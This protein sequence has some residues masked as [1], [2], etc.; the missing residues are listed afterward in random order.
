MD[1]TANSKDH[2][3]YQQLSNNHERSRGHST[4]DEGATDDEQEDL[5]YD[6]ILE[7]YLAPSL[8]CDL[9]NY[10]GVPSDCLQELTKSL[11]ES[12]LVDISIQSATTSDEA[13]YSFDSNNEFS[14]SETISKSCE[15]KEY[16]EH[17]SENL[18]SIPT[19][20]PDVL[21]RHFN[22][23]SLLNPYEF[24]D[25]ETMP[26]VS[27]AESSDETVISRK[28][29]T[30]HSL[31]NTFVEDS[32]EISQNENTDD[33]EV[34][35]INELNSD[36]DQTSLKEDV[37]E[38]DE[39]GEEFC[40]LPTNNMDK[41]VQQPKQEYERRLS[42]SDIKYGQGQV[43]YK[44]PDFSKVPSK[45]KIPKGD[46]GNIKPV[47]S[48]KR[49]TS[50][51]NLS[52]QSFIIQDILDSMQPFTEHGLVNDSSVCSD[53]LQVQVSQISHYASHSK[54]QITSIVHPA[55]DFH[56]PLGNTNKQTEDSLNGIQR[57]DGL[58]TCKSAANADRQ[59]PNTE[60]GQL[61]TEGE[62]MSRTLMEQVQELKN[63][64]ESFSDCIFV[65]SLTTKEES[66]IF[67][68]LR[69]CL[70]S[71][72]LNYLSSKDKHRNLQLQ[73]Y[74]TGCQTVGEFDVEREVEGQ[75][76]RLGMLLED[77]QEQIN[78]NA[79]SLIEFP[80][81]IKPHEV[82]NAEGP[83]DVIKM[84]NCLTEK[85]FPIQE[86]ET[87]S[88]LP[89]LWSLNDTAP[90]PQILQQ[91]PPVEKN[92]TDYSHLTVKYI[93][94]KYGSADTTDIIKNNATETIANR[95]EE[96]LKDLLPCSMSL[97]S[98]ALKMQMP[99]PPLL[100]N[101]TDKSKLMQSYQSSLISPRLRISKTSELS[102]KS[103]TNRSD[104]LDKRH[105]YVTS[106]D[107]A[108]PVQNLLSTTLF[109]QSNMS[110]KQSSTVPPCSEFSGK[111][112]RSEKK[113]TLERLKSDM[114]HNPLFHNSNFYIGKDVKL[115]AVYFIVLYSSQEAD[116]RK[117]QPASTRNLS[118]CIQEKALNL[119]I[120]VG[121]ERTDSFSSN[122]LVASH[123][124]ISKYRHQLSRNYRTYQSKGFNSVASST[125]CNKYKN[126]TFSAGNQSKLL[127]PNTSMTNIALH[128]QKTYGA[129]RSRN[130]VFSQNQ[131]SL[132]NQPDFSKCNMI[133][134]ISRY[135]VQSSRHSQLSAS[136]ISSLP[137]KSWAGVKES[138]LDY[139]DFKILNSVL[140][141]TLRTANKMQKTTEK[142]IQKLTADLFNSTFYHSFCTH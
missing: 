113:K 124:Q 99:E 98:T 142:M 5:P 58:Q 76:Y 135:S 89:C 120:P 10:S 92:G 7:C 60:D 43:H 128:K 108:S 27:I 36:I 93:S 110:Q 80:P 18:H 122:W 74:R 2:H 49:V 126:R 23:D 106:M 41:E 8:D 28:S 1:F 103:V 48:T 26:E 114:D 87:R 22:E 102:N 134:P 88:L 82:S 138:P 118:I 123:S 32:L 11:E 15:A 85:D 91:E 57:E 121:N 96:M 55:T 37:H 71:L 63:K 21:L 14:L 47:S 12:L 72:E 116:L 45:V 95:Q 17:N 64:V 42:S 59:S 20:I 6:G 119:E 112:G 111:S 70:E 52:G 50:S 29:C 13:V 24:I 66:L 86:E 117:T 62:K 107:N 84:E 73:T 65:K 25:Y 125:S 77:I 101:D 81:S 137:R 139:N 44:L 100:K 51:F 133:V 129:S 115:T 38:Y 31:Y 127:N 40:K 104:Q 130:P 61:L 90:K 67:Q 3:N 105:T 54:D 4:D 109:P 16:T 83:E 19:I 35:L 46:A 94:G 97:N 53:H 30:S 75:I 78:K 34:I 33:Q 68:N 39:G 141:Q 79:E 9:E 69:S 132:A 136:A 131:V 140:D 56:H